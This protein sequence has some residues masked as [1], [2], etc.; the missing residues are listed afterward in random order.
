MK[1][2]TSLQTKLHNR[3]LVLRT[4]L[5]NRAISRAEIARL[6]KLTRT[7]VSDVVSGLLLEGLVEEIGKGESLG[8][9]TPILLSIDAD[10]RYMIGLNLSQSKFIGAIVNLKGEIKDRIEVTI[11]GDNSENALNSVYRI[12]DELTHKNRENLVGIGVGAPGLIDSRKGIIINAVNLDWHNLNLGDLLSKRYQLPTIILNDSQAAAI[13]E[14]FYNLDNAPEEN[15]IV[16]T[17]NQGIGAGIIINGKLFQG[18][19]GCAGEIDRK[20]VV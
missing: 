18:D 3:D 6:T 10:S 15:Y 4:I 12:L 9:K 13:G 1:K 19:G 17:V 11:H 8:G 7:T 16:V 5:M 2:A 20:S 14:Y